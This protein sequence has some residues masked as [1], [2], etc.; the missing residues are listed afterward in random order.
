MILLEKLGG[1][2]VAVVAFVVRVSPKPLRKRIIV[3]VCPF[4]VFLVELDKKLSKNIVIW[5]NWTKLALQLLP[6]HY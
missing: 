1:L 3:I 2:G 4:F 5:K 6:P